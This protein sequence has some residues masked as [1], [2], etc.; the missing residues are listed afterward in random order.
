MTGQVA[1]N[2]VTGAQ[3]ISSRTGESIGDAVA[4]ADGKIRAV[5]AHAAVVAELDGAMVTEVDLGGGCLIPGFVDPHNHLLATGETLTAV[6]ASYPTVHH[7]AGL[8]AQVGQATAMQP[9]GTWVRGYGMDHAKYPENRCPR[10]ADLDV[11]SPHHPVIVFHKSGHAAV[12]NSVALNLAGDASSGDPEGGYFVRDDRGRAAGYCSDAALDVVFPRA[13]DISCHGPNFHFDASAE[14]LR[15]SLAVASTAYLQAGITTVCDP[16]ATRRELMTYLAARNTG[17]LRIRVVA[18]PLSSS[19]A[20]LRDAGVGAHLG[21]EWF[22]LGAMKFYADGALTSGTAAFSPR[23]DSDPGPGQLFWP[24]QQL[25]ALVAEAMAC[26]WEVGIHAQ[27]DLGIEYALSAIEA[28]ADRHPGPFRH[29]LEHCGSPTDQQLT[30]MADI[31][32]VPVN[33]PNFLVES[34]DDLTR[35]LGNR[36]HELQPLRSE[37]ELGILAVL[38]S[39]SF[40]SNYRPLHT[41]SSAMSRTTSSGRTIGQPQQLTFAQAL[42]AHTIGAARALRLDH[43]VGAIEPGMAADILHFKEDLRE[44]PGDQLRSLS[45]ATTLIDG[46]IAAGAS[47]WETT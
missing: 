42:T 40:V 38:S 16:Q 2:V 3:V 39:D 15:H 32:V 44:V 11:V 33:Q 31:G 13:V 19:L 6:D 27:G 25:T 28:G 36:V 18:M 8:V 10:A 12:L 30:R 1:F 20:S 5:G 34:G 9:A 26:G 21:D 43:I 45:P 29:R 37:L 41:L 14:D 35:R 47:I 46:Q 17:E 4:I 22:R 23:E 7:V 24:P